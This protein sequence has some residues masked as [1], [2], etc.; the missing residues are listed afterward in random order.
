MA[1][2][3]PAAAPAAGTV[4]E[5]ESMLPDSVPADETA[6]L[7]GRKKA[8]C[9]VTGS[10]AALAVVLGLGTRNAWAVHN[11]KGTVTRLEAL[12]ASN[13]DSSNREAPRCTVGQPPLTGSST[14]LWSNSDM[15]IGDTIQKFWDAR[16]SNFSWNAPL[17]DHRGAETGIGYWLAPPE[18]EITG[19]EG[20]WTSRAFVGRRIKLAKRTSCC[21]QY[22]AGNQTH[23][24]STDYCVVVEY[25]ASKPVGDVCAAHGIGDCPADNESAASSDREWKLPVVTE[26]YGACLKPLAPSTVGQILLKNGVVV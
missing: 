6:W 24:R 2:A 10:L 4:S 8:C 20:E 21:C 17:Q 14:S 18:Y 26:V 1:A 7:G 5:L 25:E 12:T 3:A 15:Y 11:L 16:S 19:D 22:M 13:S 9:M 23:V